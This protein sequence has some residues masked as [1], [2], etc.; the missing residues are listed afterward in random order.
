MIGHGT[1]HIEKSSADRS[2]TR[3]IVTA[4]WTAVLLGPMSEI[5][6]SKMPCGQF[7]ANRLNEPK[8]QSDIASRPLPKPPVSSSQYDVVPQ[9]IIR[10]PDVRPGKFAIGDAKRLLQQYP[11]MSGHRRVRVPSPFGATSRREHLQQRPPPTTIENP[12]YRSAGGRWLIHSRLTGIS[13]SSAC[14]GLRT[15]CR[16]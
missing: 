12:T 11:S 2:T 3:Q 10:S 5:K 6:T 7:P 15:T 1:N 16:G 4:Y 14:V 9:M 8:S 13:N